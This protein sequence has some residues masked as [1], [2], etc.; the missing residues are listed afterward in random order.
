MG[1]DFGRFR[2]SFLTLVLKISDVVVVDFGHCLS[3]S[4]AVTAMVFVW[5]CGWHAALKNDGSLTLSQ[6][7]FCKA[8][9]SV[10]IA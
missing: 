7:L 3:G 10:A 6:V 2:C 1:A 9:S 4:L 8:A 5:C